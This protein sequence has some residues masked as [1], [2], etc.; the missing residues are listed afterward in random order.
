MEKRNKT[1]SKNVEKNVKSKNYQNLKHKGKTR[2]KRKTITFIL[3]FL[4]IGILIS[5]G[6]LLLKHPVFNI[7]EI[8]IEGTNKYTNEDIIKKFGM[9]LNKNIFMQVYKAKKVDYSDFSY[10]DN[11]KFEYNLPDKVVL[12]LTERKSS[13]FAFDKEKN[14]FFRINEDGYI[15]EEA[16]IE[17][18]TEDELLM[19]GVTFNDKVVL[20]EKINEIDMSK[21]AVFLNI[22]QA[23]ENSKIN[24][25]I[26][27]VNF[28]NS[29]TTLTLN[30]KLNVIFPNNDDL[31]YKI[32]LL[33]EI[34]NNVGEDA[35][36]VVDLSKSTPTYSSF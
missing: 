31:N 11:V 36:G 35:V 13:Y 32:A 9:E 3:V 24:K 23:L 18:K 22:K 5:G 10:L 29:L 14:T 7:K 30:D 26:T 1:S 15:L 33:T 4:L 16:K 19:Y 27:K 8:M 17:Q 21:I 25:K 6:I 20:G 28:E 12:K 34:I 2:K